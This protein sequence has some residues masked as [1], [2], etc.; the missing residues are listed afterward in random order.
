MKYSEKHIFKIGRQ[1]IQYHPASSREYLEAVLGAEKTLEQ[2]CIRTPK[3]IYWKDG[4]QEQPD[5]SFYSGSAGIAYFYIKLYAATGDEK[6]KKIIDEAMDY[7]F[8][9]WQTFEVAKMS[10]PLPEAGNGFYTGLVALTIPM[11]EAYALETEEERRC[12]IKQAVR[13]ITDRVLKI[14]REEQG[15]LYW[16]KNLSM[17][18]DG[19]V[20]LQ[21]AQIADF[22]K[23][24]KLLK[25][26]ADSASFLSELAE[27]SATG[28]LIYDGYNGANGYVAPNFEFGSAGAGYVLLRF[29]EL[30]GKKEFLEKAVLCARFLDEISVAQEKGKLIPYRVGEDAPTIFYLGA[31]HG[32]AGTGKFYYKLYQITKDP[33]YVQDLNELFEG[34]EALGAPRK[35]SSGLW[36]CVNYCCGASGHVHTYIGLYL[37]TGEERWKELAKQSANIL[38][39]E[40]DQTEDGAVYWKTALDRIAPN[41]YTIPVGYY[42]GIAGIAG[43][44]LEMYLLEENHFHWSRLADDPYKEEY[45]KE[46]CNDEKEQANE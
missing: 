42:D 16:R 43:T 3:G 34:L 1:Y 40:K 24:E 45:N 15:H 35:M 29:Y 6:Y 10:S 13:A 46:E 44:L 7:L 12:E 36:N 27:K 32:P 18:Y 41:V 39:G 8:A 9:T 14:A 22:L 19:G 38:L 2:K 33:K 28:G 25:T 23:D 30:T 20:L 26:A 5:I 31:C 11:I 21:L 17:F 4:L 37:S